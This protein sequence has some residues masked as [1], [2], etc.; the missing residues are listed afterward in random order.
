MLPLRQTRWSGQRR[1]TA[2][3]RV[4]G[5]HFQDSVVALLACQMASGELASSA[6]V[7]EGREDCWLEGSPSLLMQAKSRL[8]ENGQ[9]SASG[10]AGHLVS[11]LKRQQARLE[12]GSRLVLFLEG[13]VAGE[14]GLDDFDGSFTTQV[15]PRSG[16]HSAVQRRATQDGIDPRDLAH[17][18][19]ATSV[20]GW[21]WSQ[22][23]ERTLSAVRRIT[24]LPPAA[25]QMVMSRLRI[26]VAD[27]ADTNARRVR[28]QRSSL[29]KTRIIDA[30]NEAAEL[31]DVDALEAALR[32]GCCTTFSWNDAVSGG[33]GY[34][35]G[36]STQPFHV[37]AGLVTPRPDIVAQVVSGLD[38]HSCAVIAG[39]SG[40]GKSAVLWTLPRE[41]PRT[42]WFRVHRLGPQDISQLIRLA[43]MYGA[44]PASPVGF[45]VDDAGTAELIGWSSLRRRAAAIPGIWLIAT[46][47][48][49]DRVALGDAAQCTVVEMQLDESAAESIYEGLR[50]HRSTTARHWREAYENC[51]GLTL[52]FTHLLC[53]SERLA[54]VVEDQV[55]RRARE[56]RDVELSILRAVS[57]ADRW[58][59]SLPVTR[60][61]SL[62]G[63][64]DEQIGAALRR[65]VG[66]HL[67]VESDGDLRGLHQ[68]RSAAMCMA[69]HAS[70][71]PLLSDTVAR[72]APAVPTALLGR[73][74][75][76]LL[77]DEPGLIGAVICAA[78]QDLAATRLAEYLH[79]VRLADFGRRV[80]AWK[81]AAEE[82]D[83][84]G[85]QLMLLL[86]L[87]SS[88]LSVP[89]SISASGSRMQREIA[90]A[91]EYVSPLREAF[92]AGFGSDRAA[93][94][95]ASACDVDTAGRLLSEFAEQRKSLEA[96]LL[97]VLVADC[98]LVEELQASPIEELAEFLTAA[99]GIGPSLHGRLV[100]LQGG[101][102]AVLQRLRQGVPWLLDLVPERTPGHTIVR[103]RFLH[104]PG[105]GQADPDA[106][107]SELSQ[108]ICSLVPGLSQVE[109]RAELPT[110]Q[111]P[112]VGGYEYGV[113]HEESASDVYGRSSHWMEAR[114][115]VIRSE[116]STGDTERLYAAASLLESAAVLVGELGARLV[117]ELPQPPDLSEL[118]PQIERLQRDGELLRP[119]LSSAGLGAAI[120]EGDDQARN[121]SG[122][123]CVVELVVGVTRRV[124]PDVR[125]RS[126][127]GQLAVHI[128]DTLIRRHL[129]DCIQEPW[130]LVAV[131]PHPQ[132]LDRLR[133]SL[134]D[135]ST[136]L[137]EL[138][139]A[140]A[141]DQ[142][143]RDASVGAGSPDRVLHAAA[144]Q[145]GRRLRQ[146]LKDRHSAVHSICEHSAA[147]A[148]V[149][150][151]PLPHPLRFTFAICVEV[152]SLM[153]WDAARQEIARALA[154]RP[155][156]DE[157]YVLIPTRRG[158]PV[159][160]FMERANSGWPVA[161]LDPWSSDLEQAH[162]SG[163]HEAFTAAHS[164]SMAISGIACLPEAQRNHPAIEA[165][166]DAARQRHAQAMA[167][168]TQGPQDEVVTA[169]I[170]L[171]AR[172]EH[173]VEAEWEP[174]STQPR[175]AQ[176]VADWPAQVDAPPGLPDRSVAPI[177]A[178]EWDIDAAGANDLW[179]AIQQGRTP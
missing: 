159:P 46:A 10:A 115:R 25:M 139:H 167:V 161:S 91:G 67:V 83:V 40:V 121:A 175:L 6:M 85:A 107:A 78:R 1:G 104:V 38:A 152:E 58:S 86:L 2:L 34:Y 68:L 147:D 153:H 171:L 117:S 61:A 66:E 101:G 125:Q 150:A 124:A 59:G 12:Q 22:I 122:H 123:D 20:V 26:L 94:L 27:T 172:I 73:F 134:W 135:L 48:T 165:A 160:T 98:P 111:Q 140:D 164:A 41:F 87:T 96:S 157:S 141:D 56:S 178:Q 149:L 146:R 138:S 29:D 16:F 17:L 23:A 5:F 24:A 75:F 173:I 43:R 64:S 170:G 90:A 102:E 21:T 84:P 89:P 137:Y 97:R 93:E 55:S 169:L 44:G 109:V 69:A 72:V 128:G 37:A 31:I 105:A 126:T 155:T 82:F 47:R 156:S 131:E 132:A 76:S 99:K 162:A 77:R 35:E 14:D 74:V 11:A 54:A 36:V 113:V 174:G 57:V 42:L 32:S 65:L 70:P 100:E 110:G 39:P 118:N 95:V 127:Y 51:R 133:A 143:I 176:R 154:E 179:A 45:L 166:A 145:C 168:M 120:S 106:A 148:R 88:G 19:D 7:P 79:G 49:E 52:E 116:I 163:L 60:L 130:R 28:S 63:V 92:V 15:A 158:R 151:T 8:P 50:R 30:I 129:E 3:R 80:V 18:L 142:A 13:G 81:Q 33:D 136:V 103:C 53:R 62:L 144:A 9:L 177:L 112:T 119:A 71:P 114:A 108:L 4:V